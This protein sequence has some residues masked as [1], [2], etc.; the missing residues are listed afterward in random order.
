MN[1]SSTKKLKTFWL[2]AAE[3]RALKRMAKVLYMSERQV[4]SAALRYYEAQVK[5]REER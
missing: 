5:E 4:V 3:C 2:S 1:K